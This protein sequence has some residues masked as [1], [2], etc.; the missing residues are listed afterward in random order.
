MRCGGRC[1]KRSLFR[2]SL[3]YSVGE[4]KGNKKMFH[5]PSFLLLFYNPFHLYRA[6]R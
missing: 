2:R 4:G 3:D 1:L 6:L 5:L